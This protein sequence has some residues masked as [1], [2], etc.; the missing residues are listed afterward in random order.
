MRPTS[1]EFEARGLSVGLPAALFLVVAAAISPALTIWANNIAEVPKTNRL[2]I[3]ALCNVALGLVVLW[4]ANRRMPD[5]RLAGFVSFIVILGLSSGGGLVKNLLTPW[6]WV[7]AIVVMGALVAIIL[8]LQK[9]W[10]LDVI[11]FAAA[12]ALVLPPLLSGV[13]STMHQAT[14]ESSVSASPGTPHMAFRPDIIL[15]VLDGYT[16]LPVLRDFFGYE[17]LAFIDDLNQDHFQVVNP[18]F[19]PYSMTHLAIP[20]LLELDYV[21]DVGASDSQSMA[22]ILSGE[23]RLVRG[24]S[25]NE[26]EITMIEP[27]WHMS[28]CGPRIDWCIQDPFID[29]AVEAVLSQ[30][31][32]WSFIEPAIGSAFT[33]GARHAMTL[34]LD[35][36]DRLLHNGEPDFLFVHVLAPHP[37]LFLDSDCSIVPE[38][39]RLE[40]RFADVGGVS[41]ETSG[42]RLNGYVEQVRCVDSFIRTLADSAGST[43]AVVFV[44]G[45]HGSDALSQLAT[46]PDSWIE[47]QLLDRMSTF[48][49][50][51]APSQCEVGQ[52]RIT[53]GILRDLISCVGGFNINPVE[54]KAF[55]VSRV[56]V[57]GHADNIRELDKTVLNRLAACLDVGAVAPDCPLA[58]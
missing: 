58:R 5:V 51:K 40:T 2:V 37:P 6:K 43:D 50:I 45:D 34:T 46:P 12:A 52:S 23:S 1:S 47:A 39:V 17:D 13:W 48:L 36:V 55:V 41:P 3:V 21:T 14:Q 31:M 22:R 29:E 49:A 33:N 57:E 32:F 26:Y 16:S 10:L 18:A 56:E 35:N 42:I 30:S 9:W 15:V 7:L 4:L 24:L 27:G 44:T 11:F 20:S 8:R 38:P 25:E 53:V 54:T 19:S 28:R